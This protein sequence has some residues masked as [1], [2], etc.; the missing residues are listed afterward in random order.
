MA[1]ELEYITDDLRHDILSGVFPPGA[2]L[3]ELRLSDRYS[4]GRAAVR[5]ALVELSAE[6]LVDREANRGA[7]V[8]SIGIAEVIQITEARAALES[9]IAAHAAR[10][11]SPSQRAQLEQIG[12][13]MRDAVA[14]GDHDA[15]AGLNSELHAYIREISRHVVASHLVGHLRNRAARHRYQLATRPGRPAESLQQHVAIIDA[16]V[17]GDPD[18]A[19]RAMERH[20]ESV[21]EVL[22][23]WDETTDGPNSP[24]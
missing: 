3:V 21:I 8:R 16:I 5:S 6:G 13:D 24:D 7:T 22:I 17:G 14:A 23:D 2:R 1:S 4:C 12:S 11:A 9:L 10:Y 20:L 19:S 15:Y 18:A